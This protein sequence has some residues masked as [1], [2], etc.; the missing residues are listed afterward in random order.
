MM[1]EITCPCRSHRQLWCASFSLVRCLHISLEVERI[2]PFC[3]V[4]YIFY[5]LFFCL[6]WMWWVHEDESASNKILIPFV[7]TWA[8]PCTV[9][10]TKSWRKMLLCF[11]RTG[12][13]SPAKEKA[14]VAKSHVMFEMYEN[15]AEVRRDVE[16][17]PDIWFLD[18]RADIFIVQPMGSRSKT[19]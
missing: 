4:W 14:A 16:L 15:T 2:K 11:T 19:V 7:I 1:D 6:A 5:C 18:F 17:R 12:S 3:R 13:T 10:L 8:I 9:S